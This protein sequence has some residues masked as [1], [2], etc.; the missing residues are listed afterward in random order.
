[1]R[2][3]TKAGRTCTPRTD[4]RSISTCPTTTANAHNPSIPPIGGEG[5]LH[6][7]AAPPIFPSFNRVRGAGDEPALQAWKDG[8]IP[9]DYPRAGTGHQARVHGALPLGCF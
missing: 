8:V 5:R 1:M 4:A 3:K 2:E 9:P 6:A 7:S